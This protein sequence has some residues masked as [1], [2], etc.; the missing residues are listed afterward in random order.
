MDV[1]VGTI[2]KVEHQRTD[3]F[4]LWCWGRLLR[5]VWTAKR[6][7]QSILKEISPEYSW[8]GLMLKMKLQ[9]FGHL[10]W[11]TDSSEK[12]L[13]LG[14]IEGGRRRGW[15]RMRWLDDI[16]DS[17]D[18]SL[19]RLRELVIDRET[20]RAAVHGV[21]KS[22]MQLSDWTELNWIVI[23]GF[24][25]VSAVK[26]TPAIQE[27]QETRIQSLGQEDS[28]KEGMANHSSI[29]AWSWEAI[30]H[31]IA[32]RHEWIDWT[33]TCAAVVIGECFHSEFQKCLL[34]CLSIYLSIYLWSI[35]EIKY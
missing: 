30:F 34:S 33:H 20:W 12:T 5:V 25:D 3:A 28:L 19:S 15:Q 4:E 10:M 35:W 18:M 24:P 31:R 27:P 6:A 14:K 22:W 23:R 7:N 26:N 17:M 8:E 29:L 2:K 21:A 13:M 32:K 11:S 16:T 1:R 9:Y